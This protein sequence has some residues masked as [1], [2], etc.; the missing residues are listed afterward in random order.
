MELVESLGRDLLFL[1]IVVVI[2]WIF[3]S[4]GPSKK[5]DD[6]SK[7]KPEY[8]PW[9]DEDLKDHTDDH[10]TE[11]VDD[12]HESEENLEH[13]PFSSPRF[14]EHEM[15]KRSQAF[16]ELLNQRR[17]VR[18]ISD[19]P[20]PRQVIDNVIRTAG[21]APSGAHTEPWSFVVV[22]DE[23]V[24]HKIRV[25]IEDEEEINYKKRMGDRWVNDLKKLRTNWIKEYLDTA[26]FLILIF[27]K[28][29]G[30]TSSGRKKTHYYNEIS[31]SIACGILL[32][33]LQN[34]GLVT[35]TTT[36]LNCGPRLRTLLDRP[37]N[38]K[39]LMLLP[40]GYPRKDATVPNLKRKP[41]EE[42]MVVV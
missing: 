35:V 39:L 18:F 12:F 23:E 8:Q 3:K 2:G 38:E 36:P 32:A 26:P 33:A 28:I 24:K 21:T 11:D 27:K 25:I 19:E 9:V 15:I 41:L 10:Q 16:Y 14:P 7:T 17:S 31:V 20:V 6:E 30:I 1:F 22:Q 13:I 4:E 42:I 5:T 34:A 37:V 40:V 29:Y